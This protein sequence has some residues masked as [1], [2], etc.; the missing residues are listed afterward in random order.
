MSHPDVIDLT[1][2]EPDH[3]EDEEVAAN[4]VVQEVH[5]IQRRPIPWVN[6]TNLPQTNSLPSPHTPSIHNHT[7][8]YQFHKMMGTNSSLHMQAAAQAK[9]RRVP[10]FPQ[11]RTVCTNTFP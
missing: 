11:M 4:P 3:L 1:S 9:K 5:A 8:M 7:N 2:D 10:I 6:T